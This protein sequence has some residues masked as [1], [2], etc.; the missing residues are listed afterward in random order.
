MRTTE[1]ELRNI[2]RS[3]IKEGSIDQDS[4]KSRFNQVRASKIDLDSLMKATISNVN[5]EIYENIY[6]Q[7]FYAKYEEIFGNKPNYDERSYIRSLLR[8]LMDKYI[9]SG[10]A[11]F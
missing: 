9:Q 4:F 11:G 6:A 8:D 2:I 1:N 3:V 5:K 10:Y 7:A